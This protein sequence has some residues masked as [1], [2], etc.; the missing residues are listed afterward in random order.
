MCAHDWSIWLKAS[1]KKDAEVRSCW[2]CHK[3]EY[4]EPEPS[5][6]VAPPSKVKKAKEAKE[7]PKAEAAPETA[8]P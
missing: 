2:K 4:K 7:Q 5:A 3:E 6:A 1:S 8:A